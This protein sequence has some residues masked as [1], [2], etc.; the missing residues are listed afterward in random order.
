M[1]L[2]LSL[3]IHLAGGRLERL[4]H[5]RNMAL[6]MIESICYGPIPLD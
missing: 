2:G 6:E 4:E 5:L 1:S 3:A